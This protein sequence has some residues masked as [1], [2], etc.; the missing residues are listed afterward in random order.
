M[1]NKSFMIIIF[2]SLIVFTGLLFSIYKIVTKDALVFY[3][4]GYVSISDAEKSEK[5]YFSSGTSYKRG[6]GKEVIFKDVENIK[7]EVGK[8]NFVFYDNKSINFLNDG[9]LL[10]LNQVNAAFVPYYNIKSNY[11]IEYN[12]DKYVIKS[13]DKDIIIDNFI[14]R[15]SD[16]KYI[17]A[18]NDLKLK[19]SS[20]EDLVSNY[21]FELNFID[22]QTVKIDNDKLNLETISDE[23]YIMVGD[24]I[25]ID[26][27]KQVIFYEDEVKINLS[28]IIINHDENIDILYEEKP[29]QSGDSEDGNISGGSDGGQVTPPIIP[30]YEV[31]TVIEY[32]NVPYVELISSSVNSHKINLKFNVIDKNSLITGP[33]TVRYYNVA[34]K[35]TVEDKYTN[36]SGTI[37]YIADGLKSDSNYIVSIYA[38]YVRND[39]IY[40]DYVMFQRTFSTKDLGIELVKDYVTNDELSYNINF[41]ENATFTSGTLNLYDTNGSLIDSYDFKNNGQDLNVTFGDLN[42][43]TKYIAKIENIT[44][45]NVVYTG[46]S[47]TQNEQKTLKYNPF[48]DGVLVTSP[49]ATVNKKDYTIKLDLGEIADPDLSFKKIVYNIYDET[50]GNIIKTIEKETLNSFEIAIDDTFKVSNE[51]NTY[52]Y[53]FKAIVTLNDNEK[54]IDYETLSSNIFNISTLISPTMRFTTTGVTANTLNG[55][56]TIND[57]D[58]TLDTSKNIYV[59][60]TS[61]L[62]V[63]ANKTLEF[64]NCPTEESTTTKCVS[65]ELT[66]LTSDEVYTIGLMGYIDL[67]DNNPGYVQIGAIKLTTERADVIITN[68]SAVQL[69]DEAALEK[70]FE[71]NINFS[72]D[73]MTDVSIKD[74]MTSFDILLYEGADAT[75]MYLSS[76]TVGSGTD[77]VEE[78]FNNTKVI[79]LEDFGLS[80]DEIRK[81][82]LDS[83]ISKKYTIKLTNGRSGVDFVEFK[84]Q[85]L[86]FEINDVLLDLSNNDATIAVTP[87]LN[88]DKAGYHEDNLNDDTVVGLKVTP[89]FGNKKYAT[90]IDFVIR[91]VTDGNGA[92]LEY[93]EKLELDDGSIVPVYEFMFKDYSNFFKRGR[94]Y[95]VEYTVQLD[96]NNDGQTDLVYPFSN[97]SMNTPSPVVSEKVKV[98]KQAPSMILFPWLSDEA[99]VTFKYSITD[100]DKALESDYKVYYDV[101]GNMMEATNVTCTSSVKGYTSNYKCMTLNNLKAGD[102]Y[103]VYLNPQLIENTEEPSTRV[104]INDFTFEGVYDLANLRYDL[105]LNDNGQSKYNNMFSLKIT[106]PYDN[107]SDEEKLVSSQIKN[108]IAYYTLEFKID[109]SNKKFVIDNITDSTRTSPRSSNIIKYYEGNT[110]KASWNSASRNDSLS[111]V[112]YISSC[113]DGVST[114]LYVDYSQLYNSVTFKDAFAAFKN[115]NIVVSLSAMYDSGNISYLGNGQSKYAFQVMANDIIDKNGQIYNGN[116]MLVHGT[117][118]DKVTFSP[119]ALAGIYAYVNG[120]GGFVDDNLEDTTIGS[121]NMYLIN[122]TYSN[123]S[124][125]SPNSNYIKP[126]YVVTDRGVEVTFGYGATQVTLPLVAKELNSSSITGVGNFTYDRVIPS[127]NVIGNAPTINGIKLDLGITGVTDSDITEEDGNRYVYIETYAKEDDSLIKNLKINKNKMTSQSGVVQDNKYQ[128]QKDDDYKLDITSVRTSS[129][130]IENYSYDYKTGI[131]TFDGNIEDNTSITI[132]YRLVIDRLNV[133]NSYYLKAYMLLDNK[134]T[135]LVDTTSST[136]E[137]F[138]YEF[139]TKSASKIAI[140]NAAMDVISDSDYATRHLVTTYNI[141]DIIGINNLEYEICNADKS[142][143]VDVNN[144]QSCNNSYNNFDG[145][146]FT[147]ENSYS[148]LISHDV[149]ITDDFDFEYNTNYNLV[150]NALVEE[151]NEQVSKYEIYNNSISLRALNKPSVNVIKNAGFKEGKNAYLSFDIAFTDVDRVISK[152]VDNAEKGQYIVYLAMG[153]DRTEIIGTRQIIN[154][155]EDGLD[156]MTTVTFDNLDKA[157]AYYLMLEYKIYTNNANS[158]KESAFS[159]PY[160][161]YTLGDNGVSVG[162]I[163]YSATAN[164]S[165]LKFGYATNMTRDYIIPEEGA[166]PIPDPTQE[167]YV[168]GIVYR[169]TRTSGDNSFVIE[170][171]L[172]FDDENKI[173]VKNDRYAS[174]TIGDTYYQLTIP[175]TTYPVGAGYD[176]LFQFYLG[177]NVASSLNSKASCEENSITNHWDANTNECYILDDTKYQ[178]STMYGNGA[179]K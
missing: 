152:P 131:I 5:V 139:T 130:E 177:G 70:F 95:Q 112:A 96:L 132:N 149:S 143:C 111:R 138:N 158:E 56:F 89:D 102:I 1:K 109:G 57:S 172:I 104:D 124:I 114:C 12:S 103:N 174:E 126:S 91:D 38:S 166:A 97:E 30:D 175:N 46:G 50:T 62:G 77:I 135:Y 178:A 33:V 137:T 78:Y 49:I 100:I 159:I 67:K 20:S 160:L 21:Y 99:S 142:I 122:T 151:T 163:E 176:I 92:T 32:K 87:I 105:E 161:I 165:I 170:D 127:I 8:F 147:K 11:L 18:G 129:G 14:G 128:V 13:Q 15:I 120:Q 74:N 141:D 19:L 29:E 123:L 179:A 34:T 40:N 17:V 83:Q 119:S 117:T 85:M 3:A 43:N 64:I 154:V 169:I 84:P 150:I 48:K 58:N 86:T 23:C 63:S 76:L 71:L 155:T 26:L 66:E 37:D 80:L 68:M 156:K 133:D 157:S 134:K 53:S 101:L 59:E 44:F 125:V 116:Y 107:L 52:N 73:D 162:R 136:Y 55:Y 4:D 140:T 90:N 148:S 25:K 113:D 16:G 39:A 121:G 94:I 2:V 168:A 7:Q 81:I 88:N 54:I 79:T 28:E 65:L 31:E 75:G 110:E 72:L 146:C 98:Q 144:Y 173:E 41:T 171:T 118:L 35:E 27:S 93:S 145:T 10:D 106:E 47:A 60:Y 42:S 9:V 115:L 108:R 45:G 164:T 167:A 22:G 61:S 6:Y 69:D 82:H 24:K 36:Y 153:L 51:E